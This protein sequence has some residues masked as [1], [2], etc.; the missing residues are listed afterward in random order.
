[1]LKMRLR[2][3]GVAGHSAYPA[4]GTSAV[5]KLLDAIEALR[6]HEWPEDDTLGP[7]T[8]NIGTVEG[9]VAANVFA[10]SAEAQA[11]FRTVSDTEALLAKVEALVEPYGQVT[12]VVYNDPVFFDP[13]ADVDT[14]TVPFNTDATYLGPLGP[15]WLVGPGDIEVAHSDHEHIELDSLEA[16]VALYERLGKLVL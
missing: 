4:R 2:T 10:P 14:C 15:I 8:L 1:M 6:R 11:L 13:P 5:H 16:G 12:N 9:G 7:T 3:D